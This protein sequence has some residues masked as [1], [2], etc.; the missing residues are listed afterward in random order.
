MSTQ[1]GQQVDVKLAYLQ[2]DTQN[3][4]ST[5]EKIYE[6]VFQQI[7]RFKK[8]CLGTEPIPTGK[9]YPLILSVANNT[10]HQAI[11][12]IL[13]MKIIVPGWKNQAGST[14]EIEGTYPLPEVKKSET[15]KITLM[16]LSEIPLLRIFVKKARFCETDRAIDATMSGDRKF[17]FKSGADFMISSASSDPED[18]ED[19]MTIEHIEREVGLD[20]Y[21]LIKSYLGLNV[22]ARG[23]LL[24]VLFD[25]LDDVENNR[26]RYNLDEQGKMITKHLLQIDILSNISMMIEDLGLFS[27]ALRADIR[28]LCKYFSVMP[29]ATKSETSIETYRL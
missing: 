24:R 3:L 18:K 19:E 13:E 15:E 2:I 16:E 1:E 8:E 4:A 14:L 27:V 28:N 6:N 29:V 11:S 12:G 9:V 25:H 10:A 20:N 21:L 17:F 5:P 7:H 26:Q 23:L 22:Y